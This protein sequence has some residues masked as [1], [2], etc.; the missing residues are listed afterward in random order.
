[1]LHWRGLLYLFLFDAPLAW[2]SLLILV[3][4][5]IGA[6]FFTYSCSMLHWRGLLYLFLFHAPMAWSSLLILVPCSNGV[7]Y[8][9]YA[10]SMF[11]W[12]VLLCLCFFHAPRARTQSVDFVRVAVVGILWGGGEVGPMG[13][14]ERSS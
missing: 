11:H 3:P 7:V 5:F 1:M 12:R 6:V 10:Y 8:C 2:S 4:C 13:T 14:V 9:A